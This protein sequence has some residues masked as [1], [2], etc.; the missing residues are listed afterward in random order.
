MQ[1]KGVVLAVLLLCLLLVISGCATQRA[2]TRYD[3]DGKPYTVMVEDPWGTIGKII[4]VGMIVSALVYLSQS[5]QS[6]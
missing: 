5:H 2:E 4:L 6:E 1:R 3:S